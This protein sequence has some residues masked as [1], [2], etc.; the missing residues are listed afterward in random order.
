MQRAVWTRC[1]GSF[2]RAFRTGSGDRYGES[3]STMTRSSGI[4]FA[5]RR[6]DSDRLK[7]TMPVRLNQWPRYKISDASDS[8]PVKQ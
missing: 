5:T 2:G 1:A 6:S 3:V 8:V 4:I 7:V